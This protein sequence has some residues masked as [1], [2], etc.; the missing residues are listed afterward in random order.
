MPGGRPEGPVGAPRLR[1]I[2]AGFRRV[3]RPGGWLLLGWWAGEGLQC[4]SG[5]VV[6]RVHQRPWAAAA[7][8]RGRHCRA[9][10]L[11]VC[12]QGALHMMMDVKAACSTAGFAA[13]DCWQFSDWQV[14]PFPTTMQVETLYL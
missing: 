12:G 5:S 3:L 9:S 1:E 8:A 10:R 11:T 6:V 7:H 14:T 2:L 13:G 4:W